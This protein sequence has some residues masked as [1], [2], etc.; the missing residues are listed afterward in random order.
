MSLTLL[1]SSEQVNE[2]DVVLVA[3]GR[4][5]R[6]A[7]A[8]F[9]DRFADRL[10]SA[11]VRVVRDVHQAEEV[12]QEVFLEVWL[13]AARFDPAR[14]SAQAWLFTMAHRRAI[15]RVRSSQAA[16]DRDHRV[17][18]RSIETHYDCVSEAVAATD[19]RRT[20]NHS[21]L[22]LT[23]VQ[24][25]SIVLAFYLGHTYLEVAHLTGAP[26]P[27][28]KTRIRDSLIRLRTTLAPTTGD[29]S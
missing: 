20:L 22:T 1:P 6:A 18:V 14:G 12:V 28:V 2:P 26:L 7:F 13:Q 15:D 8:A 4:G 3:V 25:Q 16:I 11:V 17:A 29:M 27:T 10:L 21:L 23:E 5:D 19:E 24:R 9:H